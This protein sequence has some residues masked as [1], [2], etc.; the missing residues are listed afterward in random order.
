MEKHTQPTTDSF[1][2]RRCQTPSRDT[3]PSI[4]AS[5]F[6]YPAD[7]APVSA[8]LAE[9]SDAFFSRAAGSRCC[10]GDS[11]FTLVFAAFLFLGNVRQGVGSSLIRF[12]E[13]LKSDSDALTEASSSLHIQTSDPGPG[14]PPPVP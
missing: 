13:K 6:E 5:I 7:R 2:S 12:G 9:K 3:C 8:I 10:T 14:N 4:S 1:E 11:L